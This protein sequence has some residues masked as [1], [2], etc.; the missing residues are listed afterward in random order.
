MTARGRRRL[1]ALRCA[2]AQAERS[3]LLDKNSG[4][5]VAY[6]G[7]RASPAA[8]A[9]IVREGFKVNG[10][11]A[12]PENGN[13]HGTGVA[14]LDWHGPMARRAAQEGRAPVADR[15]PRGCQPSQH[16]RLR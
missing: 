15:G 4:W 11:A 14:R 3:M 1:T 10:G 12:A 16:R 13:A 9:S 7:T 2:C 6:H 8:I 5:A